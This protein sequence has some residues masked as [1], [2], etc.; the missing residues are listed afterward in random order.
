MIDIPAIIIYDNS[1]C[2]ATI[3]E[4][5]KR[6]RLKAG[7][8][9]SEL[10]RRVDTSPATISRYENG[11]ERFEVQ[12]L[13]K[14]ADALGVRL[15]INFKPVK[16][17]KLPKNERFVANKIKRLFWDHDLKPGDLKKYPKW[18]TERVIE[19]GSLEDMQALMGLFGKQ[20]FLEYIS[21][22]RFG[23][24][25]TEHFWL[26]ILQKEGIKCTKKFFPRE[27]KTC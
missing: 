13:A 8:S 25:K 18:I 3:S 2:A 10:A 23:S 15:D 19:Y 24:P 6:L 14:L 7:L 11:W 26:A 9:L 16:E 1:M 21:A 12:T 27:A 5:L 4:K 20:Q 22:C 17:N